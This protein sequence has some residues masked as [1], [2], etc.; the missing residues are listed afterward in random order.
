M[1]IV[2][3]TKSVILALSVNPNTAQDTLIYGV[4][5]RDNLTDRSYVMSGELALPD[6]N[7]VGA[8]W[9]AYSTAPS[10]VLSAESGTK[11]VYFRLKNGFGESSVVSDTIFLY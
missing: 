1:A 5:S 4:G 3:V 8:S 7:F 6:P 9:Q 11:T 2:G 10:F